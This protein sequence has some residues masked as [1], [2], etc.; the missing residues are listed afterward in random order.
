[1][2]DMTEFGESK[3]VTPD[4]VK[5]S[6]SRILV[7]ISPAAIIIDDYKNRRP[8]FTVNM[9]ARQKVWR[10]NQKSIQNLKAEFGSDD[11]TWIGKRIAL[12]IELTN[13]NKETVTAY[14][15]P[16]I[17]TAPPQAQGQTPLHDPSALPPK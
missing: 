4:L 14:P 7:I 3:Y 1:M 16:V 8:E 12:R 11:S 9:D 5:A 13:N 17:Q 15:I 10:P 6:P 2:T